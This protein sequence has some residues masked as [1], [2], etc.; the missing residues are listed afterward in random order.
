MRDHIRILGIL[1]IVLGSL[2][3][4]GGLIVFAV[5]GGIAGFLHAG[6]SGNDPDNWVA[7][8]IVATVGFAISIFLLL[9]SA[10]SIVGGWGLMHYRPWS[11]VLMVIVSVFHCFHV[12]IGTALGIYGFWVLFN[13]EAQ[14]ILDTGGH[15]MPPPATGYAPYAPP[16]PTA[17]PPGQ[18]PTV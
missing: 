10:P 6:V 15:Y 7:A 9:L 4:A 2:T 8:P 17:Y 1:N 16:A 12:P 3:A 13:P 14:R 11:R 18:P 5:L